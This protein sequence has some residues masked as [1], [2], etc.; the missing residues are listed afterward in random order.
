[1][2]NYLTVENMILYIW[3]DIQI[4]NPNTIF[5]RLCYNSSA[6]PNLAKDQFRLDNVYLPRCNLSSVI[7]T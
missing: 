5:L 4:S 2:M 6:I 1:M 3:F 7:Y